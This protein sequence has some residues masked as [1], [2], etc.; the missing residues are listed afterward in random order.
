M[1]RKLTAAL[2][3]GAAVLTNVASTM[4]SSIFHY[5]DVSKQSTDSVLAAFRASQGPISLWFTVMAFAAALFVPIAIGVG[6]LSARPVMRIAVVVGIAAAVV[7]VIGLMRWPLLVPRHA[8]DAAGTEPGIVATAHDSFDTAN[9]LLGTIIGETCGHLLTAAWTVLVLAAL[10]RAGAGRWFTALGMASAVL[11]TAGVL[12]PL[13][14]P[15][16]GTAN[17]IGYALWGL[18]LIAFAVL[19]LRQPRTTNTTIRPHRARHALRA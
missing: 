14:L 16:V 3:I 6:K 11:I 13:D 9:L 7:Q 19:L 17:F 1:N 10:T 15:A 8:A 5:P 4:L 12:S 18:W 2:L